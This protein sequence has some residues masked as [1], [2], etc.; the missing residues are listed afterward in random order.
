MFEL[1]ELRREVLPDDW[2][3]SRGL[4]KAILVLAIRSAVC[5]VGWAAATF[6]VT[7][8]L[9][10]YAG[11]GSGLRG[12]AVMTGVIVFI[13]VASGAIAAVLTMNL[14]DIAGVEGLVP[15]ML[16]G[17]FACLV[18]VLGVLLVALIR[19]AGALPLAMMS[20]ACAMSLVIVVRRTVFLD[21]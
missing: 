18:I 9:E 8:V 15:A 3:L 20:L 16:A 12:V 13:A 21:Y 19:S 4:R 7:A 11:P 2:T 17:A 5:L 14:C 6:A 10:M 1:H